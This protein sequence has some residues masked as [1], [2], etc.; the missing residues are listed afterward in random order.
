LSGWGSDICKCVVIEAE[1]SI[2]FQRQ[3]VDHDTPNEAIISNRN[4]ND[5][6]KVSM[7]ADSKSRV[8]IDY[9]KAKEVL[10]RLSQVRR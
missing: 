5:V 8:H 4:Y 10:Y 7:M 9:L 6:N 1:T 3:C 2:V